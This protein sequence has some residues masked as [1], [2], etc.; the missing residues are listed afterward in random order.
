METVK[1]LK[2]IVY[3]ETERENLTADIY[4]PLNRKSIPI[5]ILIHGG[6]FQAGSK[7]MYENWGAYLAQNGF[8]AMSINYR[9]SGPD[10]PSYPGVLEDVS[11]SIN[12]LVA[13]A[14]EWELDPMNVAFVGDSAGAY[15]STLAALKSGISSY[16]VKLIVSLYGVFD[17]VEWE[18]YTNR[19][20]TDFVVGKLFGTSSFLGFDLY[21]E[22]NPMVQIEKVSRY[23]KFDTEFLLIY[24]EKD[25]IVIPE[26]QTIAFSNKL[27]ALGIPYT[28]HSVS[29]WGHFWFTKNENMSSHSEEGDLTKEPISKIKPVIMD[30]LNSKL[31]KTI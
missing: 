15:L 5:V 28:I 26:K 8:C 25:D 12:Y 16:R 1:V 10:Y 4:L 21:Q 11:K 24:G 14:N 29:D 19:T 27:K 18:E 30:K 17:I 2:N 3:G 23:H 7:E 9:L 20:R 31:K 22:A 13:K 6:A